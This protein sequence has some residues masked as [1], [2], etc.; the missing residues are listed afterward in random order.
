MTLRI[1]RRGDIR[2]I[3]G[4]GKS[5][6]DELERQGRFPRRVRISDRA[7]GWRSDEVE[8]WIKARPRGDEVASD[9]PVNTYATKESRRKGS[10][11]R[12]ERAALAAV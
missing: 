2:A 9:V 3:T 11:V 10:E 7:V 6:I 8:A 1:L 12:A 4:L 5:R